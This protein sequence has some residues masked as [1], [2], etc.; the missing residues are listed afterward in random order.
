MAPHGRS[1]EPLGCE[2]TLW[3]ARD[4]LPQPPDKQEVAVLLMVQ[5][6]ELMAAGVTP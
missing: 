5:H 3:K 1:R 2:D 6:V 4:K